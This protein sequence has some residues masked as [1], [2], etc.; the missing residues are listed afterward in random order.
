[1]TIPITKIRTSHALTIRANSINIG[2]INNWAFSGSRTLTPLYQIDQDN[3]GNPYEYMP[4]NA[5]GLTLTVSRYDTYKSKMEEAFGTPELTMLTR[6]N[7]P[8]D[9]YEVWY[10]P[11][12]NLTP[13]LSA[14]QTADVNIS[15]TPFVDQERYVFQ[16]CWFSN[17]GK[18]LRSDDNRIVN[19]NATLVYT[20]KRKVTGLVGEAINLLASIG[21]PGT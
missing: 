10:L 12:E 8:F 13:L 4:G 21:L 3:S 1:M 11:V 16:G 9:I 6:Q 19:A 14:Y 20:S 15:T 5:T 2:L 17:L 7:Q 18:T